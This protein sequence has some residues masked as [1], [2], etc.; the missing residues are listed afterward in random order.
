MVGWLDGLMDGWF[1]RWIDDLHKTFQRKNKTKKSESESHRMLNWIKFSSLSPTTS[2]MLG[3]SI[4]PLLYNL[5]PFIS[6]TPS[7][8]PRWQSAASPFS[9]KSVWGK[10][11][12]SSPSLIRQSVAF[13]SATIS[14]FSPFR[15]LIHRNQESRDDT[16]PF[17]RSFSSKIKKVD[18]SFL[19]GDEGGEETPQP[20]GMGRDEFFS[21]LQSHENCNFNSLCSHL[22]PSFRY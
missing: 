12:L 3:R 9:S 20:P 15:S 5:H 22:Y 8:I 11:V 7:T 10:S 18:D 13:R 21:D 2:S 4:S 1:D 16:L 6:K 19:R 14:P 17:S